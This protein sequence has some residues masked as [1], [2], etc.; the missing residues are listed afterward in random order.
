MSGRPLPLGLTLR[1]ILGLGV[2]AAGCASGGNEA[3]RTVRS[4]A[5]VKDCNKVGGLMEEKSYWGG[6]SG[7]DS[8][9]AAMRRE[10]A[11][12][13]ADTLLIVSETGTFMP[14]STGESYRCEK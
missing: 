8:N 1:L 13:G 2:A 12:R 10:T 14:R 11:A 4:A 5:E 3:V 7:R 6:D 9:K